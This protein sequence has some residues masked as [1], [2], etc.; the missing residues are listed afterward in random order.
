M[1]VVFFVMKGI[2]YGEFVPSNATVNSDFYY[3]IMR[4]LRENVQRKRMELWCNH[5][6]LLHHD[7]ASASMSLTTTEFVTNSNMVISPLLSARQT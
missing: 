7:N 4:R 5:N 1:F 2:V 6:W 3:D